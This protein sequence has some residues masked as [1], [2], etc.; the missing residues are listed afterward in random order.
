MHSLRCVFVAE[1]L[2][3]FGVSH[4]TMVWVC[5]VYSPGTSRNMCYWFFLTLWVTYGTLGPTIT[6]PSRQR[7]IHL[8]CIA[9]PV[10][11]LW[12]K[13]THRKEGECWRKAEIDFIPKWQ[14]LSLSLSLP[15]WCNGPV[16]PVSSSSL[17]EPSKRNLICHMAFVWALV[18]TLT[19]DLLSGMQMCVSHLCKT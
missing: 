19:T 3:S 10:V 7:L 4:V 2:H 11:L 1:L 16:E 13:S 15:Y 17:Y 6:T 8:C 12:F 9:A 18:P 14:Y 5:C